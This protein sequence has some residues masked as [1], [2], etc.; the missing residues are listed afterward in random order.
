MAS[1]LIKNSSQIYFDSVFGMENEGMVKIFKALESSGLKGFL[2]CSSAIYEAALVKFFQNASVRDDK[3]VSKVQGK[4]VEFTEE[5]F[6]GTFELPTEGLTDMSD[7]PKDLVFDARTTFSYDGEQLNTSCKKREMKFEF[8]LL[9]DILAKT[10]TVK[11]GSF[12]A[13]T[14]E[15][16]LMMYSIHGGV[17]VNWGRLLFNI[18]K[19]MVTPTTK[20]ARVY[21]MQICILLKSAPDLDLGESKDFPP[22][23]ILTAKTVGTYVAKNKNITV[24]VDDPAGDYPVVKN[25]A[26]SKRRPAPAVGDSVS[27]KKRTTVG[28]AALT[29]K[30]LALVTVAQDV[31]PI[32]TVQAVTPL[33]SRHRA[34]KRKLV[35]K[36]GSDDE[37]VDSIIHQVIADA[38]AIETGEPDFE[39]PGITRSDEIYIEGYEHSIPVNDEDD[40]IDG[41]ENE[42]ARKMASAT[43]PEQFLKEPLRSGEDDD[44]SGFKQPSKII[45]TEKNKETDIEPVET[46]KEKRQESKLMDVQGHILE[47]VTDSEDTEPLSKALALTEKSTSDE[48]SM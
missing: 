3:V 16:F 18:F 26:A 46:E 1:A 41:A 20:Q 30:N 8:L 25:K 21:A 37:I 40:N 13:V 22:L 6:A 44:M 48:E 43:A 4:Y 38:A 39:V 11:A 19:D 33:A 32:S 42:I 35:L 34:P 10:V 47:K 45:E 9:N 7:V 15:R 23:K 5:V 24:D 31:E 29:D 2:G 36:T 17:K 12:D 27:K 28:R 14:H